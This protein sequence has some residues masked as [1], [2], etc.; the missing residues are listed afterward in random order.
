MSFCVKKKSHAVIGGIFLMGVFIGIDQIVK[1]F[2]LQSQ[3]IDSLCNYGIAFGIILPQVVF[4]VLWSAIMIC[5]LYFW[6]QKI[7][8]KCFVQLPYILILSGGISNTIDRFFYGCV[9]DYI[10]FLHISSFNIADAFITSGAI[11]IL[12]RNFFEK[13][14]SK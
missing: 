11:L 6:A 9:V 5:I 12:W 10:P 1:W 4:I 13:E 3:V 7:S 2:V 8:D 14:K